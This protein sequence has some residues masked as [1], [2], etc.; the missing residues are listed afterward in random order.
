M[1]T[2]RWNTDAAG[3]LRAQWTEDAPKKAR[4][5]RKTART[6]GK[7]RLRKTWH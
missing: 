5:F 4:H 7:A 2:M 6:A 3:R 1:V